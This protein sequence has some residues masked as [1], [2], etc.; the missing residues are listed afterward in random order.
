MSSWRRNIGAKIIFLDIDGVILAPY[1]KGESDY[2]FTPDLVE[3]LKTIIK[4]TDAKIII[5]SSWRYRM[6]KLVEQFIEHD[7]PMFIDT[8][9]H[10]YT[11]EKRDRHVDLITY[12]QRNNMRNY[13]VIDDCHRLTLPVF[14]AEGSL[15][16][17]DTKVGLTDEHV[18]QA[19]DILNN[20]TF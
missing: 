20:K 10:N 1:K 13:V 19:I 4:A 3:R 15:I 14:K 7:I 16:K 8:I 11:E 12:M 17:P 2:K 5:S 18:E 6:D 9:D